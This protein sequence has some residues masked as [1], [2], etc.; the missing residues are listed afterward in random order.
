MQ[1]G[2]RPSAEQVKYLMGGEQVKLRQTY[3][4][5]LLNNSDAVKFVYSCFISL[6]DA[7]GWHD[8]HTL[9]ARPCLH[10]LRPRHVLTHSEP[11]Q[12]PMGCTT[13]Y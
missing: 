3:K 12:R 4:F 11:G 1:R 10:Q 2:R 8:W 5:K 6:L 7:R 9:L 13:T